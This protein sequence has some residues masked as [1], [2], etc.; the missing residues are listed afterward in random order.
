[1]SSI[2]LEENFETL[3]KECNPH[4]AFI[5]LQLPEVK[6]D[7]IIISNNKEFER[8]AKEFYQSYD[9]S[10]LEYV[11]AFSSF[12]EYILKNGFPN[13]YIFGIRKSENEY[14]SFDNKINHTIFNVNKNLW[15]SLLEESQSIDLNNSSKNNFDKLLNEIE[16]RKYSEERNI[17]HIYIC[18]FLNNIPLYKLLG[19]NTEPLNALILAPVS[20]T[21]NITS[22]FSIAISRDLNESVLSNY[23]Y[24]DF[25]PKINKALSTISE[26]RY[27]HLVKKSQSNA[28]AAIMSRQMSHN[29]GSHVIP[30]TK[31]DIKN[32]DFFDEKQKNGTVRLLHYLQE[33][34][35]FIAMIVNTHEKDKLHGCLNLKAHIL[36]E[37]AMDGPAIRHYSKDDEHCTNYIL[38]HIVKSENIYRFE[39]YNKIEGFS[40]KDKDFENHVPI[41]LQIIK[42]VE[43][44]LKAFTSI[45]NGDGKSND[46]SRINIQIP[47]GVNGRHAFLNILEDFIRN[48]AK[49]NKK[50]LEGL[51]QLMISIMVEENSINDASI[52]EDEYLITIFS[53]K[54]S[55]DDEL[56]HLTQE[57]SKIRLLTDKN[58]I[59][60]ER[61]GLKE[62]LICLAWLKDKMDDLSILEK[63]VN[64]NNQKFISLTEEDSLCEFIL[65]DTPEMFSDAE[66]K[67]TNK[68]LA[69][70]F[71]LPKY[72]F[73][74][75]IKK[76]TLV[77]D[78]GE[79]NIENVFRLPASEFYI[80]EDK[81]E[82]E[83]L[84]IFIPHLIK[85]DNIDSFELL[86]KIAEGKIFDLGDDEKAKI[87][88]TYLTDI[89]KINLPE[90]YILST[91][92]LRYEYDGLYKN[93]IKRI[94]GDNIESIDSIEKNIIIYR[95]H[96]D[97]KDNFKD[98]QKSL[99]ENIE[100]KKQVK[101]IDGISG[102]NY[103]YNLV[104]SNIL[105]DLEYLRIVDSALTKI[106]IIDERFFEHY[107]GKIPSKHY[108]TDNQKR[109]KEIIH[110]LNSLIENTTDLK[111][112]QSEIK[113]KFG[114]S[115][116]I[117]ALVQLHK[118][119]GNI[120]YSEGLNN[121]VSNLLS[122]N[123][124]ANI[125][126]AKGIKI[127]N[128]FA[129]DDNGFLMDLN[130]NCFDFIE[131]GFDFVSI[132][133]SIIEKFTGK[134][135]E[136]KF[137]NFVE[138]I[139]KNYTKE[140][141][142]IAIHSGRGNITGLEKKAT[143]I[144]VSTIESQLR[145]C[146]Y[147]L[148]QQFINLKFKN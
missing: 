67:K 35:D 49:H 132:H 76:A 52:N 90:L 29:L 141:P 13:P 39:K 7:K 105:N 133:F 21:D 128:Y 116:S 123:I 68:H 33:R 118:S 9:K 140:K 135:I 57:I 103:T 82:F 77:N 38:R 70:R 66:L 94:I 26:F 50:A 54:H 108:I 129:F 48:T 110:E 146:K 134:D 100:L 115:I 3:V 15:D 25:L 113:K 65:L 137:D 31:Y 69:L 96:N 18:K 45:N 95:E 125:L 84:K 117:D 6:D 72:R 43:G 89:R 138:L 85:K 101:Y 60:Q 10:D 12:F 119:Y 147:L 102:G 28:I 145:N 131:N 55:D 59:D 87:Y 16:F 124:K 92:H 24:F 27:E 91:K 114:L 75:F 41:E 17:D 36:D 106:A 20:L 44:E 107:G 142:K 47:Y 122:T 58:E 130:N 53:N 46:F 61:K 112:A 99:A 98:A 30:G 80:A 127:Y 73:V 97:L 93:K 1:M 14:S 78:T 42:N 148:F 34:M 104:L 40:I 144:P 81:I 56:N 83:K 23:I 2:K 136:S 71:I 8:I 86:S 4:N 64:T 121:T 120:N 62:M 5:Y 22:L 111:Q 37:I 51:D 143:F 19:A 88:H 79:I 74:Y 63:Q 109:N 11:L 126:E 139:Y 32:S